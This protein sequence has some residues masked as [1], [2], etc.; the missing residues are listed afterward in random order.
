MGKLTGFAI[1]DYCPFDEL[2]L[3]VDCR[4][5]VDH[6]IREA[7]ILIINE[8]PDR[9]HLLSFAL[10]EAPRPITVGDHK[11]SAENDI[12]LPCASALAIAVESPQ[13]RLCECGLATKSATPPSLKLRRAKPDN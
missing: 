9:K 1:F 7:N 2:P 4:R 5:S 12:I 3:T 10:R 6:G 8:Q 13:A 11:M